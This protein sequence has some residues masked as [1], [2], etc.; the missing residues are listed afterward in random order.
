MEARHVG[1]RDAEN[2]GET[3]GLTNNRKTM[4][5]PHYFSIRGLPAPFCICYMCGERLTEEE[6]IANDGCTPMHAVCRSIYIA[7]QAAELEKTKL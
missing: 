6:I 3:G 1:G 2:D 5:T 4:N 7:D